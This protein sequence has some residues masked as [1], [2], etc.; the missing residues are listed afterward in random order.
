MG[1]IKISLGDRIG[2]SS[3]SVLY[4]M[5]NIYRSRLRIKSIVDRD[6]QTVDVCSRNISI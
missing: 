5:Q 2:D 6:I 4:N 3:E 1:E